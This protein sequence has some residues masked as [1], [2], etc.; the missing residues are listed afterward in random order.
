MK[1]NNEEKSTR[2]VIEQVNKFDG[3]CRKIIKII[4]NPENTNQAR[5]Y[6]DDTYYM[7]WYNIEANNNEINEILKNIEADIIIFMPHE[8]WENE[9]EWTTSH[10]QYYYLQYDKST[11]KWWTHESETYKEFVTL[12]YNHILGQAS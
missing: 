12:Q 7:F 2:F 9:H 8:S 10:M 6:V 3:D 4:T 5:I 11:D 1:I